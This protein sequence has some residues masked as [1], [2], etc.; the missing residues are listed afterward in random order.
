MEEED[1][2]QVEDE[3]QISEVV[4]KIIKEN[5]QQ[6]DEY[7]KG[8]IPLIKFFIGKGMMETKGKADPETLAKLFKEKL[9]DG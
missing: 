7:K 8:K 4:E 1:L 9:G 5:P 3:S 2:V 6:V